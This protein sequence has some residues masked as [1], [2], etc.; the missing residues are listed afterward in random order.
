MLSIM[1]RDNRIMT[2]SYL[3]LYL[4]EMKIGFKIFY[5]RKHIILN[6]DRHTAPLDVF[7]TTNLNFLNHFIAFI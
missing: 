4:T 3:I 6:R 2:Y 1:N 7:L 5:E